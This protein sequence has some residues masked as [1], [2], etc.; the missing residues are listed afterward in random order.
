MC[1]IV[2]LS[3]NIEEI[4]FFCNLIIN[5]LPGIQLSGICSNMEEFDFL[6]TKTNPN[7]IIIIICKNI[8]FDSNDI[9][10]YC[11]SSSKKVSN[12]RVTQKNS[13]TQLC[14]S[15]TDKTNDIIKHVSEFISK[16][17]KRLLRKKII[18]LLEAFQYDFKL[19]GT[20]YILESILYCYE[21][22]S[23]YI[24]EN[25]E[26]NVYPHI[27]QICHTTI[28]KVKWSISRAT[29]IM[30]SRIN[31]SIQKELSDSFNLD[32]SEKPTAKQLITSIVT[33]LN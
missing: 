29:D 26:K 19:I 22:K 21:N 11:S 6:V 33:K 32:F 14:I 20:T 31:M 18:K 12:S 30:N 10:I 2:I 5:R 8:F 15:R 24:F 25:L 16:H 3:N 13:S 17:D 4:K 23:D 9:L 27:A 1:K 28:D 7:I